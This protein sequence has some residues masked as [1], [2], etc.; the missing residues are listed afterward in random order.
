MVA[1]RSDTYSK[2]QRRLSFA[3]PASFCTAD[4]SMHTL[5]NCPAHWRDRVGYRLRGVWQVCGIAF[6][7]QIAMRLCSAPVT[8]KHRDSI[9][10][11]SQPGRYVYFQ[12]SGYPLVLTIVVVS[13]LRRPASYSLHV[14]KFASSQATD[15]EKEPLRGSTS[16]SATGQATSSFAVG[17]LCAFTVGCF[18]G[19]IL[20]CVPHPS[21][22]T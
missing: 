15:L 7:E 1:R 2:A 14:H 11:C 6:C 18:G 3:C 13:S 10:V 22:K 8:R 9:Q 20:V 4:K 19:S 17:M 16:T 21:L 5:Q 12:A